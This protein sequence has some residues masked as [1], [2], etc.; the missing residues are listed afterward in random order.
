MLSLLN[1]RILKKFRFKSD[2]LY[3]KIR[4]KSDN[5]IKLKLKLSQNRNLQY[6]Y[7][8][9]IKKIEFESGKNKHF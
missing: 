9:N 2:T 3:K 8:H 6:E 5:D 7:L 1:E 4:I